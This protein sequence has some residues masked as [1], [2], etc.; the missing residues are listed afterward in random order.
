MFDY[1]TPNAVPGQIDQEKLAVKLLFS[2]VKKQEHE[3][4]QVPHSLIKICRMNLDV[5]RPRLYMLTD[6]GADVRLPHHGK[7]QTHGKE[8]VRVLAEDLPVKEIPPA[9]DHLAD[10]KAVAYHIQKQAPIRLFKFTVNNDRGHRKDDTAVDRK[11]SAA[12]VEDFRQVVLIKVPHENHVID[13]RSDDRRDHDPGKSVPVQVRILP[14]SLSHYGSD[15]NAAEHGGRDDDPIQRDSEISHHDRL[16]NI[17]Q[18]YSQIREGD[19]H[20]AHHLFHTCTF[21]LLFTNMYDSRL[22]RALRALTALHT[23]GIRSS[24]SR[25]GCRITH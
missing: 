17:A 23:C 25:P 6:Q 1:G 14:L 19:I 24:C 11:A 18:I 13:P 4:H 16:R 7:G 20:I 12:Q 21:C 15:R 2:A 3:N 9:A 8:V 5:V 22:T 10:H